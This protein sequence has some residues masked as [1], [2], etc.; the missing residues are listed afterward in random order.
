M[1]KI[2]ATSVVVIGIMMPLFAFGQGSPTT[3]QGTS[4]PGSPSTI[5]SSSN[6]GS[7][8]T[9]PATSNPGSPSTLGSGSFFYLQNPLSDKFNSIGGIVSGFIQIVSYI[10]VIAGVLALIW[11]G[12]QF[13]LAQ[14]KPDKLR[15]LKVELMWI[16]IGIAVVIGARIIVSV[17]LNTLD[18][19][20][21]VDTSTI[22]NARSVLNSTQ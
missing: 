6:P 4:N 19:T 5:Q 20:Q 2:L 10:A 8:T 15:D 7:P 3:L 18:A 1:K 21:A 17:V 9:I 11:K 22:S 16:I 13:V 14:G 12:L